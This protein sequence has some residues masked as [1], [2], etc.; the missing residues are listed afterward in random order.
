MRQHR[1]A[2]ISEAMSRVER[3]FRLPRIIWWRARSRVAW[4]SITGPHDVVVSLTS[5]GARLRNVHLVIETIARG[6]TRPRHL[7]LWLDDEERDRPLPDGVSRLVARGLEV[8]YAAQIGPHQKYFPYVQSAPRHTLPLVTA[9]DDVIYPRRWLDELLAA[10]ASFPGDI[11]ARRVRRMQFDG[12][13]FA[14]YVTW[15]FATSTAGDRTNLVLGV[16]GALYPPAFL[17]AVREMGDGFTK[18]A[19]RNDDVWLTYVAAVA[20]F[21]IRQ[22]KD[23]RARLLEIDDP[24]HQAL[25]LLNAAGENDRCLQETFG[26]RP[27]AWIGGERH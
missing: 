20:G 21:T 12:D 10:A 11:H 25:W 19:S 13:D 7:I 2:W 15:P 5:H 27:R 9:D 1:P 22:T 26:P 6:T 23:H 8:R 14:P 16:T 3:S 17:D 24:G 4:R 18:C